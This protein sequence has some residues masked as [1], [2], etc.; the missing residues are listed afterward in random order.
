MGKHKSKKKSEKLKNKNKSKKSTAGISDSTV[1]LV[2]SNAENYEEIKNEQISYANHVLGTHD[3]T[4][5]YGLPENY[6]F[7]KLHD[8]VFTDMH[9][10]QVFM[11][12]SDEQI[13]YFT[14]LPKK[15]IN[16]PFVINQKGKTVY[17]VYLVADD[18]GKKVL[19]ALS[20]SKGNQDNT[21]LTDFK[22]KLDMQVAG[23]EWLQ[24]T[25]YD[26]I[27]F[28]HPNYVTYDE[29]GNWV[30]PSSKS[31]VG[32]APTPHLHYQSEAGQILVSGDSK[33]GCDYTLAETIPEL[34]SLRGSD[35]EY[36]KK[37]VN[38]FLD[39]KST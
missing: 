27:G 16:A 26:S 36:F 8:G 34:A 33:R 18:N 39:L 21:K 32:K 3:F 4:K 31:E 30:V 24:L 35:P 22:L 38:Y 19:F 9:L 12:F 2:K 14:A 10:Q 1:K 28:D 11:P 7:S 25:R 23:K 6:D 5:E 13:E 15:V 37:C 20:I 29:D 17:G